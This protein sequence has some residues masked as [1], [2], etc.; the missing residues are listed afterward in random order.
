M[1]HLTYQLMEYDDKTSFI[2]DKGI[3]KRVLDRVESLKEK[4][5]LN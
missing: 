2:R 5:R 1:M 4:I 3:M